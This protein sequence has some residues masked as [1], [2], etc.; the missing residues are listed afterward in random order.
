MKKTHPRYC[1]LELIVFRSRLLPM[2]GCKKGRVNKEWCTAKSRSCLVFLPKNGHTSCHH[3]KIAEIVKTKIGPS[4]PQFTGPQYLS[5]P[6]PNSHT[7]LISAEKRQSWL[8]SLYMVPKL[9]NPTRHTALSPSGNEKF[10]FPLWQG[11]K[12]K[13]Q[14]VNTTSS[15]HL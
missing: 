6:S 15:Q 2:T 13:S 4:V 10:K 14:S 9:T 7:L 1:I 8:R 11:P 3:S 12:P 5:G